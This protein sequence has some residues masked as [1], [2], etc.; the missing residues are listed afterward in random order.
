MKTATVSL[1]INCNISRITRKSDTKYA[2]MFHTDGGD[3]S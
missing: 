1:S 3:Y 2:Y